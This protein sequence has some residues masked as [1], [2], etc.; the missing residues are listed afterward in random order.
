MRVTEL[1]QR[2]NVSAFRIRHYEQLGLIKAQRGRSGYREFTEGCVREVVF[3]AMSR[4]LGF[5]LKEIG[6]AVA[7]Y[8]A[9]TL[10]FD[11]MIDLMRRRLLE[12]DEQIAAHRS[13]RKKLIAHIGWLTRRQRNMDKHGQREHRLGWK[14]KRT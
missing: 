13:V 9:G 12:V 1:A 8:R 10:T 2:A 14:S 6:P 11:E 4:D 5:S 3:I 7:S